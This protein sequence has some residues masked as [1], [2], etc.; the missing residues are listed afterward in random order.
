[1]RSENTITRVDIINH[2]SE[3]TGLSKVEARS[4][5]EHI[6]DYIESS[7]KAGKRIEIRGFGVFQTRMAKPRVGRNIQKGESFM[8]PERKKVVFKVSQ[9]LKKTIEES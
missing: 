8:I 4:A 5:L 9:T 1:M 3:K 2:V 7:L 6:L